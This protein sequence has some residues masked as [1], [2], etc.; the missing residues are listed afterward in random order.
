MLLLFRL[1]VIIRVNLTLPIA[2]F[3]ISFARRKQDVPGECILYLRTVNGEPSPFV[4]V[5]YCRTILMYVWG[6]LVQMIEFNSPEWRRSHS[7]RTLVLLLRVCTFLLENGS[8]LSVVNFALH[9]IARCLL[10]ADIVGKSDPHWHW[11]FRFVFA[12]ERSGRSTTLRFRSKLIMSDLGFFVSCLAVTYNLSLLT[13]MFL[14]CSRD[15]GLEIMQPGRPFLRSLQSSFLKRIQGKVHCENGTLS[16]RGRRQR[17]TGPERVDSNPRATPLELRSDIVNRVL[18][19]VKA[20]SMVDSAK[21]THPV[22]LP[23]VSSINCM[24]IVFLFGI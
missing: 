18:A 12:N 2:I 3:E 20:C 15:S 11:I 16:V 7:C 17:C 19:A 22:P 6:C 21:V 13:D 23:S 9:P 4:L 5:M 1:F 8:E 10:L 14:A 24:H